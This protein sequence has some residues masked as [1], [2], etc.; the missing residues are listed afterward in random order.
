MNSLQVIYDE[1]GPIE[2]QR[3][4]IRSAIETT[5]NIA[6][7]TV[8]ANLGPFNGDLD[9]VDH[10]VFHYLATNFKVPTLLITNKPI[11]QSEIYEPLL[12]GATAHETPF[13]HEYKNPVGIVSTNILNNPDDIGVVTQRVLHELGHMHDLRDH[14]KEFDNGDLCLMAPYKNTN[15][16]NYMKTVGQYLCDDCKKQIE[17]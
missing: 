8:L 15:L 9:A 13:G 4:L 11:R 7:H 1:V 6:P 2:N 3:E 14:N 10:Q 17:K 5:Y 12:F 16:S